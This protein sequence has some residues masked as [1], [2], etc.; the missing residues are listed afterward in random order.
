MEPALEWAVAV[1]AG[2]TLRSFREQFCIPLSHA[3]GDGRPSIY[4]V[5]NSLGA[6]PRTVPDAI[7]Q[8]LED[9]QRL[10]VEAHLRGRE[11]WY[12]A[13]EA[14]REP[15]ARLV[16]AKPEE[17]VWMNSL[18]VNLHLMMVSFYRPTPQRHRILIEDM[19]FPS[20]SYAVQSQIRAHGLDPATSLVRLRPREG[21]R[22]I[23]DEDV[24]AFLEQEGRDVALVLLGGVNY[25]TGQVFDM[26]RI[27]AAAKG[28]GARI[29]WDLAHG[30]GNIP[31]RL[32]E[33]GPDFAC[34]CSYKYLNGGPGAIAGCFIHERNAR[35]TSLPRF[36]GWWG[37]DPQTRFEMV[38]E[39][40]PVATADAWQLSNPPIFS[41]AP[42]R[43]SLKIFDEAGMDRLRDKSLRLTGYTR[44]C[45]ER[46]CGDR[47]RVITPGEP[48][49]H[50]CQLSIVVEGDARAAH[51][52]LTARGIV[53]DFREPDIIRVAPVPLYNSFMDVLT[54]AGELADLLDAAGTSASD[55]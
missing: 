33:W 12:S 47:V 7:A 19:A 28:A 46:L 1:D 36:A 54:F 13:H 48:D 3:R 35:D 39:F 30:A 20:D 53:T 21:E 50:G 16:G 51:R 24:I 34:W 31:L 6:M 14:L 32:H 45:L 18:T 2:D 44:F 38:R 43:E 40:T 23:R 49:R 10:G 55:G 5:G 25:Q 8:E 41:L 42:V 26:A 37:N 27:S 29:G 9:W 4:L 17:V 15:G 11:P 22:T 52:G